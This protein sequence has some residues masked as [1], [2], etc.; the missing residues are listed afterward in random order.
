MS[1]QVQHEWVYHGCLVRLLHQQADKKMKPVSS[2]AL[3][4]MFSYRP[5]RM[6]AVKAI[7]HSSGAMLWVEKN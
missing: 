5:S 6:K 7:S 2:P 4:K 3:Q 1:D